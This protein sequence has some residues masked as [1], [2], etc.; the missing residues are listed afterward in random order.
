[1]AFP[2]PSGT[3]DVCGFQ[4]RAP[5]HFGNPPRGVCRIGTAGQP[6]GRMASPGNNRCAVLIAKLQKSN[7]AFCFTLWENRA[8]SLASKL[9]AGKILVIDDN[10]VIRST[11]SFALESGGYAVFTADDGPEAFKL[12]R[13]IR[14]DLILLDIFFP[15][16][17]SQSG[18]S[19]DAFMI[20]DW[21][22]HMGVIGHTPIIV[23]SGA[24]PEKFRDRCLAGG[25]AAYFSKPIET[26]ELLDTIHQILGGSV[27]RKAPGGRQ[28]WNAEHRPGAE[29]RQRA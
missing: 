12:V 7:G 5:F 27:N 8:V 23:I 16:D 11:L 21:F 15:P 2:A 18:N 1:M 9:T 3:P 25:V 29:L 17:T 28:I 22:Q 24:E 10:Q 6:G 13:R 19:W 4:A 14:P 26:R 20:I